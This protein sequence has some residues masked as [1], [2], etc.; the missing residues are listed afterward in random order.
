M[1]ANALNSQGYGGQRSRRWG[2]IIGLV[3]VSLAGGMAWKNGQWAA[4]DGP[5]SAVV[6]SADINTVT[7]LGRLEPEG[8]VIQLMAPTAIQESRI[9][10]LLVNVGD[11][12]VAGQTIAI[13]DNRDTLQAAL[14]SAQEQVRIAQA[15]LAQVQAGAKTGEL[16]AQNAEIS[17]LQANEAGVLATQ[18]ATI[19]RLQAEVNNAR[20][21][22]D[23]YDA[24]YQRGAISASERDARELTWAT[25][26]RQLQSAQSELA[27]LRSTSQGQIQQARA[28]LDQLAEV[29]PADVELAEAE[30]AAA[31][32]A[33]QEAASHL[34]KAYVRSPQA[35]QILKI[36]THPGENIAS[37]GIAT[38]GQTDQMIAIAEVYQSDIQHIQLGQAAIVTSPV[39]AGELSGTVERIGLQVEP[40]QVVDE[41]PA[42]NIDAKVIEVQ[43]QLDDA[44]RA[45]VTGLTNLQVTVRIA[46]AEGGLE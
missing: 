14:A 34:A 42:A 38:V 23:R 11:H 20:L 9:Q 26:Q 44:A 30:V 21:E 5:E 8:E 4:I 29:R 33:V 15:R 6:L 35:G 43:V 41:D 16:Q 24:L 19:D 25:T 36:H 39:I 27:R 18:Q 32:A 17:R 12:V 2:V 28:T 1:S 13:L 3:A 40:Q 7:A 22:Y 10:E 45:Q 46:I 31:R 37:A